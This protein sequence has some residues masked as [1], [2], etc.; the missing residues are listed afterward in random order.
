M[1]CSTCDRGRGCWEKLRCRTAFLV[2]ALG[3]IGSGCVTVKDG[4]HSASVA[5]SAEA[6]E[7]TRNRQWAEAAWKKIC[8]SQPQRSVSPDYALGFMDGFD[9]YLYSGQA[10]P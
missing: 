3:F 9:E 8:L 10:Q 5:E 7:R 6:L 4:G 1:P 2:L